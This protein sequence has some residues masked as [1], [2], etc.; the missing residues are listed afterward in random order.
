MKKFLLLL[1]CSGLLL[2]SCGST[3]SN[4]ESSEDSDGRK[5][6]SSADYVNLGRMADVDGPAFAVYSKTGYSGASASLD[7][8]SMEIN[9]LMPNKKFIN[10]YAFFGIDVYA[11]TSSQWLN[12]IDVG[13]CWS[14]REGGWHVFYNIYERLNEGTPT[15]YESNIILPSDDIYDMSLTIVEEN[16][17]LF[18][19]KGRTNGATDEVR[20]EVKGA[21]ADG[22]NTALLFN[23]AL[24]YPPNTKIGTDGKRSED[25][26]DITLANTDKGL[27]MR[28]IIVEDLT[29]YQG[30]AAV[31][32]TSDKNAAVSIWPDKTKKRFDYAPTSVEIFD[33]TKYIIHFDMNRQ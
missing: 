19:I 11:G 15:W 7:L 31:E 1:L 16:Y 8:A 33:G 18:T 4:T 24:D 23:A 2:T 17:A 21:A 20:V 12:C 14:G 9:T 28:N 25:F 29:L 22:H 13:H 27:Y 32:W 5:I 10:G 3:G 6:I 26:V 30:D